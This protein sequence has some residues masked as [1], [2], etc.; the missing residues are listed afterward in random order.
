[1]KKLSTRDRSRRFFIVCEGTKQDNC[2]NVKVYDILTNDK[3]AD[4]D[5][6]FKDIGDKTEYNSSYEKIENVFNI[7]GKN[8]LKDV[9]ETAHCI[10]L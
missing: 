10:L 2:V 7:G 6:E 8:L 9:I 5:I 3:Y 1:M 4:L